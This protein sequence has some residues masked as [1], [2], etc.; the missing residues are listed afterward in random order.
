MRAR[1]G[2]VFRVL[3]E[4]RNADAPQRQ[5]QPV[6][7]D[8]PDELVPLDLLRGVKG[9]R[10]DA[11]VGKQFGEFPGLFGAFRGGNE[12]G[13]LDVAAF[14][15]VDVARF[16]AHGAD[17]A[18][19]HIDAVS[20]DDAGDFLRISHAVLERDYNRIRSHQRREGLGKN[21]HLPCFS[22]RL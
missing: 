22:K 15:M 18:E 21:R 16:R 3:I 2:D 6:E 13:K 9:A 5:A 17:E 11:G 7:R 12:G 8:V 10:L 4:F 1:P 20:R 14:Q 19:A